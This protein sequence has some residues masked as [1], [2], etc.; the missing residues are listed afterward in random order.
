MGEIF[1]Y[2]DAVFMSE[3]QLMALYDVRCRDVVRILASGPMGRREIGEKLREVYPTLSPRGRWVKTV[4]LEWN[5]Y[6]IRED[7]NY[8]LSDLGQ[9]LSAIPGEVGGELSDAEKV[10]ILGTM[11]LDEAQRKI[12]AELI[13]TGKSTSKD[14]W[15]VTQTER[16]LKKLGI[17]K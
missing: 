8:K 17:I 12:V 6:V 5:P 3:V 4:L 11:M 1:F 7:N 15:K 9:A 13:A 2:D 14:T 16:V 10:F